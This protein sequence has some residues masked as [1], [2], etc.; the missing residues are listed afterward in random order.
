MMAEASSNI[1]H[2][3]EKPNFFIRWFMSTNHKDIGTLYLL[4]TRACYWE[5]NAP[6]Y[7]HGKVATVALTLVPF[8]AKVNCFCIGFLEEQSEV[9]ANVSAFC[10]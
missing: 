3:H 7:Q 2:S 10:I 8:G 4:F 5:P 1:T 6:H 9:L